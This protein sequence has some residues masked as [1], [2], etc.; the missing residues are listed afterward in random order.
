MIRNAL[1]FAA[2][3]A[4]G[5]G[6]A[7]AAPVPVP[8]LPRPGAMQLLDTPR[9]TVWD[10]IYPPGI[11][12]ALHRHMTDFVGVELVST[13][14]TFTDPD[15]TVHVVDLARGAMYMRN[16]GLTHIEEG[17]VGQPQR[18]AMLIELK[19]GVSPV[20]RN[21]TAL[22]AGFPASAAQRIVD[23]D[24]VTIWDAH[25]APGDAAAPF[26]QS[27]DIFLVPIDAG[28]LRI[29]SPGE[30]PRDLPLAGGQVLFLPGGHGLTIAA[31]SGTVR[32]AV[33]ELK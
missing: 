15:G 1:A 16:R 25:W 7:G 4:L 19:D 30:P 6:A 20:Y 8:A 18:N 12:T 29:A 24:R 21:D 5:S 23:N 13:R 33:I 14:G 31:Q 22:G 9:G 11:P 3:I 26:F 10:V 32:A 2:V 28:V 27:R 17:V